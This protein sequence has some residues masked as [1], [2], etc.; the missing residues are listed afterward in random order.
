LQLL[1]VILNNT[2]K[3]NEVISGMI[4]AGVPGGTL[5]ESHGMGQVLTTD[6]PIFAGFRQ[7][8][9]GSKPFNYT[10]LSVIPDDE[11]VQEAL[12]IIND[13]VGSA[14]EHIGIFFTVPVSFFAHLGKTH[15]AQP[16]T[17]TQS[18]ETNLESSSDNES[19]SSTE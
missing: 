8:V 6:I 18:K 16:E 12:T 19:S 7:L 4:E 14:D 17:E 10:L 15:A 11:T 5:I 1:V 9:A 13:I 3:L 2:E